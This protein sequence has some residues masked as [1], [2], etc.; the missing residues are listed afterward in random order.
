MLLQAYDFWHL[1]RT[2]GVEL[3]MGGA[4]QW[5]NIT[6]GL[7]L[8]RRTS[9]ASA[10][11]LGRAAGPRARVQAAALAVGHEV[12]QERGAA[13]ASGWTRPGRRPTRSTSTGSNTDDRDVGDVPALV[14]RAD[15]RPRSRRSRRSSRAIP[16]RG[17]P[18]ARWR[19]TS[20][21]GPTAET[22]AE[23][24]IR[25][26]EAM[27]TERPDRGSGRAGVAVRLD[28]RVRFRCRA[29]RRRAP[30]SCSPRP[31]SSRRAARRAG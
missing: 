7:E 28:G 8:I 17:P 30:R 20:R 6:A 23:A 11:T 29:A 26:S 24:A 3:Q 9:T 19:A 1:H 25:D 12:R 10:R 13:T 31:A 27:F 21:R 22:A 14:H 18:S 4:D 16:R 5:G 2:M 15:P